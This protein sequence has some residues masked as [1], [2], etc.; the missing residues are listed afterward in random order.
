MITPILI[1]GAGR[2]GGAVLDGWREA[3]AFAPAELMIRDPQP[4]PPAL[5]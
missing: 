3:G 1:L 2:M 4:S 5:A